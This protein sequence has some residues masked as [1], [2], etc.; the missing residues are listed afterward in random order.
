MVHSH[1]PPARL[2]SSF[3]IDC[4]I[5][6]DDSS[7]L[8]K[9]KQLKLDIP[10]K[11]RY[12]KQVR[13]AGFEPA[14]LLGH[15]I[16]NRERLPISPRPRSRTYPGRGRWSLGSNRDA[17][18]PRLVLAAGSAVSISKRRPPVQRVVAAIVLL[19]DPALFQIGEAGADHVGQFG[20]F[21]VWPAARPVL[22]R[23][24]RRTDRT[25]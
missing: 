3:R 4:V 14:K 9:N 12:D 17:I 21:G 5:D 1:L 23:D 8:L 19:H 22:G 25:A 24:I 7:N 13:A 18:V 15:P 2:Y 20:L 6:I 16:P 10:A 11:F